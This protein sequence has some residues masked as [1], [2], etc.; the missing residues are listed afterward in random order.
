MSPEQRRADEWE[1]GRLVA[2]H[3][4][5]NDEA[6]RD[7]VPALPAQKGA[8]PRP[9]APDKVIAGSSHDRF[10]LTGEGWRF[11]QRR[12]SLGFA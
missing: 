11:A 10:I 1:C 4:D 3:A 2:I 9:T 6:R 12:G 7:E 5:L 8:M